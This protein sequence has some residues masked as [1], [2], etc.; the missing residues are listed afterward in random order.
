MDRALYSLIQFTT[1]TLLY[2]IAGTLG[3]FQFLYIDL[4][5]ILPIAVTSAFLRWL[6]TLLSWC[7][8]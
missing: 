1:V 4:F 2:A 7:W 5:L 6:T 8:C 3:D